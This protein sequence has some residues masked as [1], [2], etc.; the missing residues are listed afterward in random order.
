MEKKIERIPIRIL[1][2]H[3]SPHIDDEVALELPQRF[4]LRQFPGIGQARLV[5][6]DPHDPR[7][8]LPTDPGGAWEWIRTRGILPVGIGGVGAPFNDKG[9]GDDVS[10]TS[11]MADFLEID[12]ERLMPFLRYVHKNDADGTGNSELGVA[13][14]VRLMNR[15][16]GASG[17]MGQT[18]RW[19]MR[20]IFDALLEKEERQTSWSLDRLVAFWLHNGGSNHAW[21]AAHEFLSL[22]HPT[23]SWT[24]AEAQ[25]TGREDDPAM[26]PL[27]GFIRELEQRK[28]VRHPFDLVEIAELLFRRLP[29]REALEAIMVALDAYVWGRRRL[30]EADAEL[31]S[32]AVK[33]YS[34]GVSQPIEVLVAQSDSPFLIRRARRPSSKRLDLVINRTSRG[35]VQ[36]IPLMP[37]GEQRT[38]RM[39][40][41]ARIIRVTEAQRRLEREKAEGFDSFWYWYLDPRSL[42]LLRGGESAPET[43]ATRL[44]IEE[45]TD[46]AAIAFNRGFSHRAVGER[47]HLCENQECTSSP[48]SGNCPWFPLDL[49][50]CR[51]N[52]AHAQAPDL[53]SCVRS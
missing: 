17:T 36:I 2:T 49:Y 41:L 12:D 11:L 40:E 43:P 3:W 20:L 37:R 29:E 51:S 26:Q 38:R 10:T 1:V 52:R 24:R 9:K 35:H 25:E 4:G 16:G 13:A 30:L 46:C 50:R 33:R 19:F 39:R 28:A 48:I 18:S 32:E 31:T 22:D 42:W 27:F 15:A 6:A 5:F 21:A 7:Y 47:A 23:T 8:L 34:L 53:R 45:L 44:T 14:L